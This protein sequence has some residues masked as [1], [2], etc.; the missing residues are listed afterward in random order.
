MV[1]F[2]FYDA[3]DMKKSGLRPFQFLNIPINGSAFAV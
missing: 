1:S 3:T 2:T